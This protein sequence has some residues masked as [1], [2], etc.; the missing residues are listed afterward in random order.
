MRTVSRHLSHPV[1]GLLFARL[2]AFYK[3]TVKQV[4][5]EDYVQIPA[6][7]S[8]GNTIASDKM[9][10]SVISVKVVKKGVK[11]KSG[12]EKPKQRQLKPCC[13]IMGPVTVN[14]PEIFTKKYKWCACGM[15]AK[16]VI[17]IYKAILRSKLQGN[18]LQSFKSFH[19]R[20]SNR[21]SLLWM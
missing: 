11:V 8:M 20:P 3:K 5:P 17:Y 16:E 19:S 9:I 6:T 12:S 13:S 10:P 15:T 7:D 21:G 18:I 4:L 14:N 2:A 1:R